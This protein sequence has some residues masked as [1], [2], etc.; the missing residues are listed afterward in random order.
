ML[1]GRLERR[2]FS[3]RVKYF[4]RSEP[5]HGNV[6]FFTFFNTSFKSSDINPHFFQNLFNNQINSFILVTFMFNY[7]CDILWRSQ[8]LGLCK[9]LVKFRCCCCLIF[10]FL[11]IFQSDCASLFC[12]AD[13]YHCLSKVA[14]PLD[15]TY[16]A[17]R[18]VST[19]FTFHSTQY[20]LFFRSIY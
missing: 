11:I 10:I 12:T 14:P 17:P 20:L 6:I 3:S 5:R 15:G 18:H 1:H 8:M 7:S 13:G 16:C 2:N 4:T 19:F 9:L